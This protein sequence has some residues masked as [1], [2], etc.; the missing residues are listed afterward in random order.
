MPSIC[1]SI[2]IYMPKSSSGKA[3]ETDLK[4]RTRENVPGRTDTASKERPLSASEEVGRVVVEKGR[5]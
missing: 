3:S 1:A 4:T 5:D 2:C